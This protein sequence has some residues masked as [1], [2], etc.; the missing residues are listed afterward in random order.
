MRGDKFS[1]RDDIIT[2]IYSLVYCHNKYHHIL[3]RRREI[4]LF[5]RE[6]SAFKFCNGS[7]LSPLL[8]EAYLYDYNEQPDYEQ[9]REILR[10]FLKRNYNI[11]YP[12]EIQIEEDDDEFLEIP[13][14]VPY[15]NKNT[16]ESPDFQ[17][18]KTLEH[19]EFIKRGKVLM[20][21]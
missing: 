4:R 3:S 17:K 19:A 2:A 5:K 9:L 18:P 16:N 1:R 8:E 20:V 12:K 15:T 14:K 21:I 13:S 11:E 6:A 10:S 7:F